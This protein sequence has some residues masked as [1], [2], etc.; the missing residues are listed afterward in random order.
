MGMDRLI[1]KKKGLQKKHVIWIAGGALFLLLA[2]IMIFGD[3]SSAFRVERDK[4]TISAVESGIFNDYISVIGTVEPITTIYLDAIEGGRVTERLIE[5]GSM[6]KKGDVILKLENRQLYQTI[7]NSEASLAEKENY[8]RNTKVSFEAAQIA[9]RKDMLDSRYRMTRRKRTYE[10]NEILVKNKY[11]PVEEY[12]QSKEDYEYEVKLLEINKIKAVNDSLL[13]TTSMQTL[14]EDLV[15]MRQMYQLVRA[16][17]DDLDVKAPVDG[18]LGMLDAEVGQLLSAGQRV[19][20]INVL[21]DF[22][23]TARTDEYYIDRI[24]HGLKCSFDRSGTKYDLVVRKVLPEVRGGQFEIEMVF[25][26]AKPDNIRTG[27]TYQM[28]LELGEAG[29]AVLIPRGGFFQSTGGQWVFVLN[30]NGT[31][32]VKRNIR[33]GRQ[34]PQYYEVLEGLNTGEQVITS[35]Y[36]L[37]GN[38]DRI[39]FK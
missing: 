12:I 22:K 23:V 19:G 17:M 35:G 4:L 31:E 14:E 11:V 9:S 37:F 39:I 21:T 28:R 29:N 20:Q 30:A 33:F 16:R 36:E 1:E 24:V 5:E 18:Q 2:G 10:Q 34:N 13:R 7:L 38:A 6:V 8:L 25:E 26:G 27:Q 32:A 3:H 15:K